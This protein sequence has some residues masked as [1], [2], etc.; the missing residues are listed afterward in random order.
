MKSETSAFVSGLVLGSFL[1]AVI[2][3]YSWPFARGQ[4]RDEACAQM[5]SDENEHGWWA[6]ELERCICAVEISR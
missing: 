4:G 2:L 3:L 6:D 5:C 1:G